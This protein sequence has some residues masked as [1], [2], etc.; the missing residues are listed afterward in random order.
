MIE[1]VITLRDILIA[2]PY[3]LVFLF[4]NMGFKRVMDY[5]D[6]KENKKLIENFD[7]IHA[8]LTFHMEGAYETIHKDNILVYSLDGVK[9]SE[10]DIDQISHE[11]V[12]LTLKLAGPNLVK[13]F[14][15]LYGDDDTLYFVMLDYFNRKFEDDEIRSQA[16]D[17]IQNGEEI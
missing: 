7:H 8:I 12:K 10:K 11:F 3:V 13:M 5:F 9:P 15:R 2:V 4:F 6:Q 17:T 1:G 16:V 14:I